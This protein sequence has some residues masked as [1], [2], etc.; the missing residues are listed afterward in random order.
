M[1]GFLIKK[2]AALAPLMVIALCLCS[3]SVSVDPIEGLRMQR[4]LQPDGDSSPTPP[5]IVEIGTD[6]NLSD[7]DDGG[8]V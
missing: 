3:V 2:G 6:D 1:F 4:M 5:R 7:I 8:G